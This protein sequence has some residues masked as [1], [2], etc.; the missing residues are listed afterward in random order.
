MYEQTL[1]ESQRSINRE[2]TTNNNRLTVRVMITRFYFYVSKFLP[3]PMYALLILVCI[4]LLG[5]WSFHIIY[6]GTTYSCYIRVLSLNERA[7]IEWGKRRTHLWAQYPCCTRTTSC[8]R[9]ITIYDLPYVL[10]FSV[11]AKCTRMVMNSIIYNKVL[12]SI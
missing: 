9:D 11:Y 12:L 5:C 8:L 1:R 10:D 4:Y 6:T 3:S 7:R 2:N